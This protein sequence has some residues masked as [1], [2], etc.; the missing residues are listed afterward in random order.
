M[1]LSTSFESAPIMCWADRGEFEK[2][3]SLGAGAQVEALVETR[4]GAKAYQMTVALKGLTAVSENGRV[5]AA[6]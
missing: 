2:A 6:K 3:R 4:A 5:G 1:F